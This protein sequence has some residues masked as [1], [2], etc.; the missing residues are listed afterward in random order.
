MIGCNEAQNG[1]GTLDII[2]L[3]RKKGGGHRQINGKT[4]SVLYT[5][6]LNIQV[7]LQIVQEIPEKKH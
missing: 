5:N 2:G 1:D 3:D 7:K 6:P 4:S